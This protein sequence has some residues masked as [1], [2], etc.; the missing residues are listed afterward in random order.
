MFESVWRRAWEDTDHFRHSG[1]FFWGCEVIGAALFAV[2]GGLL[3]PDNPSKIES[4]LYP[5]V[6]I[7]SGFILVFLGAYIWNLLKAPFRQRNEA[8]T[9]LT[10]NP[11]PI[12][13]PNGN[14]LLRAMA[15]VLQTC[16]ELLMAQE[17]LDDLDKMSP[18]LVHVEQMQTRD[19]KAE[20]YHLA[21]NKL[22]AEKMVAGKQFENIL[23]DL[24]TF[25]STQVWI[26][27]A[28][29]TVIGGNPGQ[30]QGRGA[31]EI[32]GRIAGRAGEVTRKIDELS[33]Q[34]THTEDYHT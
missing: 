15:E 25:I 12:N 28:K 24:I 34:A 13:L 20:S 27:S 1:L 5:S 4:A 16:G 18:N 33:G 31:L 32:F 23:S 11:K 3:L 30:F 9:L 8:R 21:M 10:T 6:G 26:K 19:N 14:E 29:P 22:Q 7:I 17:Q 2:I